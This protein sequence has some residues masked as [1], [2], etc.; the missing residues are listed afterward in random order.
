MDLQKEIDILNGML[1]FSVPTIPENTFL[2]D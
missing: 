2:D 1:N